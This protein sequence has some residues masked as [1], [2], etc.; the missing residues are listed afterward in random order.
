[1]VI[2]DNIHPLDHISE[3]DLH[4]YVDGQL[5]KRQRQKVEAYLER[6]PEKAAEIHDY[7]TYNKLLCEA[8]NGTADE[9]VP[10]RLL[11]VLNR[12]RNDV[13]PVL[14]K[15]AAIILLC[16]LS[17]GGGW[18]GAYKSAAS[19]QNQGGT[20]GNFLH[21]IA[22]NTETISSQTPQKLNI[23]TDIQADPLNW[24]TQK[25][26]LE[27]QA[28]NLAAA[29]YSLEGRRLVMR[30]GQEFVELTYGNQ[31]GKNIKLYMKTR[32]DK[33]PPTIEFMD[34]NGQAIAHWQEGPL[35]YALTGT[36][37]QPQAAQIA[38]L[39]RN[40]MTDVPDNPPHVQNVEIMMPETVT[41]AQQQQAAGQA[42]ATPPESQTPVTTFIPVQPQQVGKTTPAAQH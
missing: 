23:S 24:L 27:M 10:P 38:D 18:L 14:A 32:W 19:Q 40:A 2:N 9:A 22:L 17:A 16:M 25:V 28:P 36:F 42:S 3:R 37:D 8:Y 12:P 31:T 6:H 41:P 15:T 11:S 30:G 13:R 5:G 21:Q 20:V 33:E 29:G 39:V 1:M 4:A 34:T 26:A 7:I 35:V